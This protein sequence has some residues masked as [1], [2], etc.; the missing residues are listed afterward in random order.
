LK[1]EADSSLE[2]LIQVGDVM[3]TVVKTVNPEESAREVVEKMNKFRI[4]SVMVLDQDK[5]V[6]IITQGDILRK[7]VEPGHEIGA[8]KARRIMSTPLHTIERQASMEQAA[9]T[10]VKWNIK[11]LP[12]TKDGQLAG[13]VTTTDLIRN[14]PALIGLL[15]EFIRARYVPLELRTGPS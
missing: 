2:G 12:V 6:G 7:V 8:V 1:S 5:P 10:M 9:R 15:Q 13:I 3:T 14:T 4:G 11:R